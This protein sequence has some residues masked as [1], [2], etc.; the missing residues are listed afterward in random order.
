MNVKL[1]KA[2]KREQEDNDPVVQQY[3]WQTEEGAYMLSSHSDLS[4]IPG[5]DVRVL[6]YRHEIMLFDCDAEGTVTDRSGLGEIRSDDWPSHAEALREH[7]YEPV[8]PA[9]DPF[10]TLG[11]KQ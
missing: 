3:V 7:G 11:E 10:I 4:R 9:S 8:F 2:V 1:I 5:V 6:G